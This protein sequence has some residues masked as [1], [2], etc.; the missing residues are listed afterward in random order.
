[1]QQLQSAYHQQQG[2]LQTIY[3]PSHN[4]GVQYNDTSILFHAPR[5]SAF[6]FMVSRLI[7]A[8]HP[9]GPEFQPR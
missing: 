2:W 5:Y 8:V 9:A 7:P 3:S 4:L 1:M 6:N